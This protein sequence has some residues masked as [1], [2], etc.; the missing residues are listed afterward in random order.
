ML[1]Y[2]IGWLKLKRFSPG[3][4]SPSTRVTV[5]IPVRNE[6]DTIKDCLADMV[7][8][9]FPAELVQIIVVDDNSTDST[10]SRVEEFTETWHQ[11]NILL[12]Q[13][14]DGG[15]G[16]FK[17][18]A[19]RKALD[20][21]TGKLILSTDADCR[22][23]RHWMKTLVAYYEQHKP[24]MISAPVAYHRE[25]TLFER[26]QTLEF[27]GLVAIGASGM[28]LRKPIMCNGA[29]LA[30]E[31]E[32]FLEMNGFEGNQA[33]ASGDDTFLM[34]K[35]AARYPGSVHFVKSEEACV[36]TLAK[37]TLGEFVQQRKRWASKT[38]HYDSV[39]VKLIAVLV[40]LYNLLI[41]VAFLLSPWVPG[42]LDAALTGFLLKSAAD[43]QFLV[44]PVLF[45]KRDRLFPLFL[46]EQLLYI[47]YVTIVGAISPFGKY[48]WKERIVS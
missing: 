6:E 15:K 47:L 11:R 18:E 46:P 40:Y 25:R 32:A 20:K 12:I 9:D 38:R 5:V 10:V 42:M 31:K 7:K 29:N 43:F 30:Y 27:I 44:L 2:T 36:Y 26:L 35:I 16:A 23:G 4:T 39:L 14:R 13:L 24:R 21:A 33:L 37:P 1:L 3:N 45:F 48:K 22:R 34:F 41:L 28:A 8:Q 17:K 19:I